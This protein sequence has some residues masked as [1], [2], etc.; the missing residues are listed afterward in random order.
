VILHDQRLDGAVEAGLGRV[1]S[2]DGTTPLDQAFRNVTSAATSSPTELVIACHGFMT[3]SYDRASNIDLRGGQGLQLCRETL[4]VGNVWKVEA[5]KGHFS[6]IWLMACGPAGTLVH[7]SR[8]FCREF[9]AYSET[10]VIASDTAQRYHP[11]THDAANRVSR[12]VLR[13]G[14]WEGNVYEF[15]P[16]GDVSN[17]NRSESPLP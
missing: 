6:R 12:R 2:V 17:F 16:N 13:F 9:A 11:G 5:L 4:Q 3:H 15:L 8:P 1:I 7:S 14:A 10:V